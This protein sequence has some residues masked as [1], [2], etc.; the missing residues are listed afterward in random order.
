VLAVFAETKKHSEYQL[1]RQSALYI[2]LH[3]QY[4]EYF[5]PLY[6]G[7]TRKIATCC[8]IEN[9]STFLSET[10][11][12]E[13]GLKRL[14]KVFSAGIRPLYVSLTWNQ[15]NR[16]G[17]GAHSSKGLKSDGE[18]VLDA[19]QTHVTAIDLSHTSDQLAS[20]ILRYLDRT[21]SSMKVIASHSNF[22]SV[23]D[24][25]RN[26]PDEL[27][28]EIAHRGGVIGLTAIRNFIG[29]TPEDYY[30]HIE[31]ALAKGLGNAVAIVA[32]FFCVPGLSSVALKAFYEEH[33]FPTLSDSSCLRNVMDEV[34]KIFG[35]DVQQGIAWKNAWERIFMPHSL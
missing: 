14:K 25:P 17:G 31:H 4:G 21:K 2:T 7:E 30:R 13:R 1:G 19:L 22:R 10:E 16:C 32:D 6:D 3:Q 23:S 5:C 35:N 18:R 20:D 29:K 28:Q 9:C 15:E 24:V 8:A 33:F 26:L 12:L 34:G 11:P 27:A